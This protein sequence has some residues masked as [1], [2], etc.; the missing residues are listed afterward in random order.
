MEGFDELPALLEKWLP[1]QAVRRD[2]PPSSLWTNL[3]IYGI[4]SGAALLVYAAM[5]SR[6]LAIAVPACVLAGTGIAWY[7]AWCG[8]KIDE[9]KWKV[10][11]PL[12]GYLLAITLLSR[13]ITLW[14]H[15]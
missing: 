6:T 5:A 3:Q 4:W 9:R 15:R 7:F 12:T 14:V 1:Q 11:L 10:L 2:S 13:A 8:R